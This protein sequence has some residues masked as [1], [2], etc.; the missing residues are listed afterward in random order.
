VAA[1]RAPRRDATAQFEAAGCV[2]PTITVRPVTERAE[3]LGGFVAAE[4]TFTFS[5]TRTFAFAV[6]LGASDAGTCE[7]LH[8]FFGVGHV[9][10]YPR[11]KAHYDDEV[12]FVVRRL[13]DLLDVVVPF[14]DEHLRPSYKREQYEAW[15][16]ALLD[17]W[18]TS[19]RRVRSCIR[20]GCEQPRRAKGLCRRHYYAAFR[21]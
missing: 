8:E 2:D 13:R 3:W 12:V 21:R 18:E 16:R 4:G 6:A 20:D 14:M 10:W 11:R 1:L 5:G 9:R 7:Q 15:R 19:A 17:Y